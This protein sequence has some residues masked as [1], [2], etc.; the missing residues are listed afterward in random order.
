MVDIEAL[1]QRV[2][3]AHD[4]VVAVMDELEAAET[5]LREREGGRAAVLWRPGG[6]ARYYLNRARKALGTADRELRQSSD[7]RAGAP[8]QPIPRRRGRQL[9][10]SGR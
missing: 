9:R 8:A 1:R 3:A 5:D 4:E 10:K 7:P 6:F 2:A